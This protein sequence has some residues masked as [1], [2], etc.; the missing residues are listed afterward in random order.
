VNGLSRAEAYERHTGRYAAELASGFVEFAGVSPEMRALDVGCGPGGLTKVVASIVGAERVIA[1]DPS[2]GYLEVCRARLPDAEVHVAA[3]EDLPFDDGM[4]DC[5]LA[6]MVVQALDDAPRAAREMLRVTAPGGV[7][8]TCVWDFQGG[9]P[10]LDAF[11]GA[12]MAVDPEGA[13]RAGGDEANPWCTR[14]GLERLWSEAGAE[15]VE[16]GDLF[17]TAQYDGPDDA[18]WA[19]DAGAG[20]SGA[21]CR[22]LD[23]P[24]RAALRDEFH[25]RLGSPDGGFS[26]TGRAWTARGRAPLNG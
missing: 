20:L 6:Q 17:A 14:A 8:A 13:R 9:M 22:S 26:L 5:V 7:M 23:A 10:L 16:C 1:V 19:F 24:T 2:A 11:W 12:A 4:F 3:A 25:C 18:F 15:G 21:Y